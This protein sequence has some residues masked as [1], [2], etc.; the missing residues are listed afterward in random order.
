MAYQFD[1]F[2]LDPQRKLFYKNTELV[3]IEAKMLGV[4]KRLKNQIPQ[5]GEK[6]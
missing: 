2:T 4:E 1:E 5:G 3:E 6:K